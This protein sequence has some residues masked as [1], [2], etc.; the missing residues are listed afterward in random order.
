[1]QNF[2]IFCHYQYLFSSLSIQISFSWLFLPE[3]FDINSYQIG[4]RETDLGDGREETIADGDDGGE[5][6]AVFWSSAYGDQDSWS[7]AEGDLSQ[8]EETSRSCWSW[9]K[10]PELEK[11]VATILGKL[12]QLMI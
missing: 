5:N 10:L 4:I 2:Q 3:R 6:R 9:R 8:F 11:V 7:F 12:D 1:M